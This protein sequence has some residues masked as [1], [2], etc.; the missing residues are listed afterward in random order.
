MRIPVGILFLLAYPLYIRRT[1][2]GAG[3]VQDQ[4]TLD[5]LIFE[6]RP[7]RRTDPAC[8][9]ACC[10][11]SSASARWSAAPISSSRSC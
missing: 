2:R 1:L 7:E 10:S 4:E 3:A 8:C 11:C 5:P 9:Y 6:R